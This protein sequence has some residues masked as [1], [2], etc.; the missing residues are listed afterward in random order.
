MKVDYLDNHGHCM[1]SEELE[2]TELFCPNCGK[3]GVWVEK[4][5]GDFYNG[6]NYVCIECNY[7]FSL[8]TDGVRPLRLYPDESDGKD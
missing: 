1:Y 5:E 6:P 3:K 4:N 8:P 7:V 2:K